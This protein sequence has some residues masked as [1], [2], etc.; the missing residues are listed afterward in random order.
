MRPST[1]PPDR[2]FTRGSAIPR[3]MVSRAGTAAAVARRT[4]SAIEAAIASK[5]RGS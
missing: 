4:A 3:A 2:A 5:T 1:R